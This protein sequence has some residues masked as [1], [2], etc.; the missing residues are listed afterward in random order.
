MRQLPPRIGTVALLALALVVGAGVGGVAAV[1]GDSTSQSDGITVSLE[2]TESTVGPGEETTYEIV[3]E[4]ATEGIGAYTFA[5]DVSDTSVAAIDSYASEYDPLF[6]DTTVTEGTV[7]LSAAMGNNIIPGSDRIVLGTITLGGQTIG[8]TDISVR[9]D[10]DV[11]DRNDRRYSVQGTSGDTLEVVNEIDARLSPTSQS[12]DAGTTTTYDVVVD[13]ATGGIGAYETTLSL[14]D[15]S[16]ASFESFEYAHDPLFDDTAVNDSQLTISAAM[17]DNVIAGAE[18]LT[19]GTVTVAGE[20]SGQADISFASEPIASNVDD[21]KYSVGTTT[22]AGVEV[23]NDIDISLSPTPQ[24]VSAG[25]TTTYDVVVAGAT[26]GIGAYETTLSLSDSSVAAFESFEHASDP[27]FDNTAVNDSQL[28]I[29]AAM[30]DNIIAGAEQTTLG[31]VTVAGEASGQADI[32]VAGSPAFSDANDQTYGVGATTGAVV[33]VVNQINVSLAPAQQQI[34]AGTNATYE[35]VIA[36][37]TGG[38]GAYETTLSLSDSTA[39]TFVAFE[40]ANDPLFD[41]TAVNDSQLTISAAM[42]DNV[43]AGAEQLTLG[44]VT[45]AGE[46]EGQTDISVGDVL[47]SNVNDQTYGVET[48]AGGALEV[49]PKTETATVEL[50]PAEDRVRAGSQTTFDVVVDAPS[51]VSAYDMQFELDG[52]AAFVDYTLTAEGTTGPL[53]NSEISADGSS[54]SLDA[55][56]LDGTHGPGET[57]VAEL[58]VDVDSPGPLDVTATQAGIIDLD[59]R[60]YETELGSASVTAVGPPAVVPGTQPK[61]I[62]N[63]G[64]YGDVRGDGGVTVLDVQTLFTS[65]DD[66]AVQDNAAFY[67]FAGANPDRVTVLD[68]QALFAQTGQ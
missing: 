30:G 67:D 7:D 51:G 24:T 43:I 50:V 1:S 46:T 64:L 13:G 11:S 40:H 6:S 32:S 49:E 58:T 56:L 42:G 16:V 33:E 41:N 60:A 62:D 21:R 22:G 37:A 54:L 4:G 27:L 55:A 45:V 23:V 12:V 10:V 34:E 35:V 63:D 9:G 57:V 39:A 61:D 20:A 65:L 15:S 48:T 2:P 44:T 47:A 26:D 38:I 36:G 53:D 31:T 25:S 59:S 18:Q 66:P 28:T 19:L 3:L 17:G 8:K 52:N 5:V 14:S 68:V 29:S